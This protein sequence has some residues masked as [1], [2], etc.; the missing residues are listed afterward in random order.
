MLHIVTA[1]HGLGGDSSNN[2]QWTNGGRNSSGQTMEDN[3]MFRTRK[4]PVP[5]PSGGVRWT[6]LHAFGRASAVWY[7]ALNQRGQLYW[8]GYDGG[9]SVTL[10]YDYYSEGVIVTRRNT[11][12]TWVLETNINNYYI[13]LNKSFT[14][15]N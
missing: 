7:A 13:R 4:K 1:W 2:D 14:L 5:T 12:S 3:E 10:H 6:D 15:N 11:S 9:N 8:T